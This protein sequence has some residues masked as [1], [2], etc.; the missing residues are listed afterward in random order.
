MYDRLSFQDE[1]L[2]PNQISCMSFLYSRLICDENNQF[3]MLNDI[4]TQSFQVGYLYGYLGMHYPLAGNLFMRLKINNSTNYS[5]L[6]LSQAIS[7]ILQ[8]DRGKTLDLMRDHQNQISLGLKVF[9]LIFRNRFFF[10]RCSVLHSS[11]LPTLLLNYA[12]H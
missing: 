6:L 5:N 3:S 10:I 9:I 2:K 7:Q 8:K 12:S 11:S 4:E 1:I